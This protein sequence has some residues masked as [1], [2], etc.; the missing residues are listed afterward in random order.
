MSTIKIVM[1]CHRDDI[2]IP[3]NK[4]IYP[5]QVGAA[6]SNKRFEGMLHDDEGENI[7]EKNPYYCELTAQYWAWK[8][9]DADYYGLFH[10][11]RY[12]SFSDKKFPTNYFA[13][14]VMET[15][16][17]KALEEIGLNEELMQKTIEQYDFILP[18]QGSF[19]DGSTMRK[20]YNQSPQH[21]PEDLT[22]VLEILQEKYPEMMP[23]ANKYL[24]GKNGYFCNM[25]IMKK[26]IFFNY[27]EWLFGILE[28]H[29]KRRDFSMYSPQ[30]YRVSGYLAE[31]LLGVY[32]TWLIDQGTYKFKSLQRPF[33]EDVTQPKLLEPIASRDDK[34]PVALVL[35]ANEY[36][37]PYMGTLL[38]SI[39][40]NSSPNRTY[41]IVV[42]HRDITPQSQ[43]VLQRLMAPSNFSLR[44]FDTTRLM[45]DYESNLFLRG[46][47]RIETYFRLL[48]QDILPAYN[49]A[50]YLDC[51]MVANHDIAELFDVDVD[52]YLLAAV[53]DADTAGLYNGFEPQKKNYMD[54]IMKMKD[55]YSY[56]QAGT[57]LFNLAEFRKRYTVTEMFEYATSYEWELL[58][59]DVLNHFAEGHVK[60]LDMRWNV[61][62][63]WLGIR[64]NDI[65]G[66][67]P[68]MLY[69]GYMDS[70]KDPYIIHY[71][72][73]DKPWDNFES[74]YADYFWSY[75]Q[76]TP[77]APIIFERAMKKK[78]EEPSETVQHKAK[79]AI[80]PAYEK[81]FPQGTA[82][83]EKI[84]FMRKKIMH[85]SK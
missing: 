24:D 74:D 41:D 20:Q 10:Y 81:L 28:E 57:I 66:R 22:C 34:E 51:D 47:F 56:F 77:F 54:N 7:S 4:L 23:A 33:F 19:V 70:R 44:F 60:Y 36:Y 58:D 37:V 26:E 9:M 82:R 43:A 53:Q 75:A 11:R 29:E 6:L 73:P 8:N 48:M 62:M 52:G 1:A 15:N 76:R 64:I 16:D 84:G 18:E 68:R 30:A 35:S 72:G 85:P 45:R 40:E 3:E 2:A 79:E 12:F 55:P 83:R 59:Q 17:A 25:F 31:R 46:H 65:I 42:L 80:R 14:A 67:A 69:Q 50:L 13:D 78:M 5:I 38:Q 49:K 32:F 27:C 71:A 61:V 21:H 39:K 63:D